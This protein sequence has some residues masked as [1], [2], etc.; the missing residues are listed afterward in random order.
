[1]EDSSLISLAKLMPPSY[2]QMV[3]QWL[4]KNLNPGEQCIAWLS[5]SKNDASPSWLFLMNKRLIFTNHKLA[6][7]INMAESFLEFDLRDIKDVH[8]Q[9][10]LFLTF[11]KL[12]IITTSGTLVLD[13]VLPELADGFIPFLRKS[14]SKSD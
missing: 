5:G 3:I 12:E 10:K 8:F 7:T 14:L 1:M 9:K 13:H 6:T 4:S 11:G 2:T